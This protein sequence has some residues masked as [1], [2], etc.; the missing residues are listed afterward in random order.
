VAAWWIVDV[1]AEKSISSHRL[2][3]KRL[4]ER[5]GVSPRLYMLSFDSD[6]DLTSPLELELAISE[7]SR[8]QLAR[9]V[10]VSYGWA[11]DKDSSYTA[12]R[13]LID[14]IT[15]ASGGSVHGTDL[16]VIGIGWDS[17][18]T[19][20]SKLL[21]D[22]IPF[23]MLA[24][25]IAWLPDQLLMPTSFWSKAALADRIA[26]G[27]LRSTLNSLFAR[28]YPDPDHQPEIFLLGHSF[29]TRIVSGL[30][31]ERVGF[32][33]V[34]SEPFAAA[35]QV[36]GAVL[37]QPALSQLNLHLSAEY[38]ILITQSQHDHALGAMFPVANVLINAYGFSMFEGLSALLGREVAWGQR[39]KGFFNLGVL[40]ESVGR[41]VVPRPFASEAVPSVHSALELLEIIRSGAGC[42]LPR[43]SGPFVID[44][45]ALI[46]H[47]S[48]GQ[49]MENPLA[50]F[51]L[52]W[53]DPL[54][55]H[56]DYRNARVVWMIG[57]V[58]GNARQ[59]KILRQLPE[60]SDE[61]RTMLGRS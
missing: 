5:D 16:A 15:E 45:T 53:L 43:C 8:S 51:T 25:A 31:K 33:T 4:Q 48:F 7:L 3:R 37:L 58:F 59:R 9:V 47:G 57:A 52:G 19:G 38:P 14:D 13:E 36:R 35:S 49:D 50:D 27:G 21:N 44:A 54:G 40:N 55:A 2:M 28:A 29:G 12:Y 11:Y 34:R 24:D 56:G 23:P 41:V 30:M 46:R 6:G 17:S 26:Y 39:S 18:L 60:D 32:V 61:R 20:F 22:I 10:I 42:G 1:A